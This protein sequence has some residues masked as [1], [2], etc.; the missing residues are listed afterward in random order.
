MKTPSPLGKRVNIADLGSGNRNFS[1]SIGKGQESRT[2]LPVPNPKDKSTMSNCVVLTRP[3]LPSPIDLSISDDALSFS[4][5][6]QIADVKAKEISPEP[7]LLAWFDRKTGAVSPKV[8]CCREDKPAWLV[9]AESRG[10]E[11]VIDINQEEYVFI[12]LG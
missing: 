9:Y 3:M 8:E 10:G 12:Y 5:A 11:I 7:M 2:C 4:I 1:D 6:R